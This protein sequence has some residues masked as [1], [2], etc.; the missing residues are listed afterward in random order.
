MGREHEAVPPMAVVLRSACRVW[1]STAAL[2][3]VWVAVA[4]SSVTV[5]TQ[6]QRIAEALAMGCRPDVAALAPPNGNVP[7]L[8][9]GGGSSQ[10]PESSPTIVDV[11]QRLSVETPNE[12]ERALAIAAM[13]KIS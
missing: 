3:V 2:I 11:L 1:D 4:I 7:A 10:A 9:N 13:L 12:K 6:H 5:L 8:N